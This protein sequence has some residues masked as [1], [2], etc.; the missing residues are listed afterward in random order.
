MDTYELER[1]GLQRIRKR[2]RTL[3]FYTDDVKTRDDFHRAKVEETK[4]SL[5]KELKDYRKTMW[6]GEDREFMESCYSDSIARIRSELITRR[7]DRIRHRKDM[8]LEC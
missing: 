8:T 5:D 2:A 1:E 7:R 4:V 3:N 6:F